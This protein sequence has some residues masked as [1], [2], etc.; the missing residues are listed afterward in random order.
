LSAE[1]F[2]TMTGTFMVHLPY[3][4]S[5]PAL[6]DLL[7]GNVDMMFD[8]LPSA[9]PHIK[10]GKLKA[11]AVTSAVR[12]TAVPELPTIAEAGGAPLKGFE[13]SS[14]FGLLAPAGAPPDMV[15]RVQQEVAKALASPAV[16]DRL[17]SQGAIPGGGSPADFARHID[18]ETKKWAQVVK[19]SGAKV[20]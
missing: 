11:L 9:L 2:K 1:L 5:G 13:A 18:A 16:K 4:G 12:S 7:G 6:I 17:V 10:A 3:R 8:N 15:S 20:D 19:A 14:W